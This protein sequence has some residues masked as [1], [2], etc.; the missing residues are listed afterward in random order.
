MLPAAAGQ[1]AACTAA[2]SWTLIKAATARCWH[3]VLLLLLLL[4][5]LLQESQR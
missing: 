5:L 1:L 2:D 4:L 3:L